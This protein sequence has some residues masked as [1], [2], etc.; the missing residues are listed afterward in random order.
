MMATIV[1]YEKPGCQTNARQKTILLE[2]SH[3]LVVRNILSEPWTPET[4]LPFFENRPVSR[5]F[6]RASPRV[7]SGEIDPGSLNAKEALSLLLSDH[8]LIRR[9]L[10]ELSGKYLAGF[11]LEEI[12]KVAG[13]SKP[14]FADAGSD[15]SCR[16]VE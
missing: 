15:P 11:D 6:N 8:L 16:S 14:V 3:T 1:F 4:L 2:L 9:P 7:R 10:I 5:W 12:S 13:F